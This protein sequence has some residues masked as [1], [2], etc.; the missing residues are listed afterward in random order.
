MSLCHPLLSTAGVAACPNCSKDGRNQKNLNL[1]GTG[2]QKQ[3]L[4][5][6]CL[7]C[8]GLLH[9]LAWQNLRRMKPL[10]A[11]WLSLLG[12]TANQIEILKMKL[13]LKVLDD[14]RGG[15]KDRI[16]LGL[17]EEKNVV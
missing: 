4:L 16:I 6:L 12:S 5:P 10:L 14:G 11:G 1:A 9:R 7:E 2:L 13:K 8:F 3:L 17:I 15:S